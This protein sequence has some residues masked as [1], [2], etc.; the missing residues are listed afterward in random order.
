MATPFINFKWDNSFNRT[1]EF[2][3][4]LPRSYEREKA[5][6][7]R[8]FAI[9]TIVFLQQ[10]IASGTTG[11]ALSGPYR[12]WKGQK[13]LETGKLIRTRSYYRNLRL[14][15]TPDGF[16]IIPEGIEPDIVGMYGKRVNSSPRS[17]DEI[18]GWL[19][20]GTRK[21]PERPH[22]RPTSYRARAKFPHIMRGVVEAAFE[23]S[24]Q[25]EFGGSPRGFTFDVRRP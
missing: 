2:L 13:G 14:D 6:A 3:D 21:M 24:R 9:D 19:E 16:A 7:M 1:H 8:H 22:W 10:K 12:R 25:G 11:A 4:R 5:R 15:I 17:Y 18:A 20:Y 23:R